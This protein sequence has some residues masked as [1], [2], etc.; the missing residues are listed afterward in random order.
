MSH[1]C[2]LCLKANWLTAGR[3][4]RS[5]KELTNTTEKQNPDKYLIRRFKESDVYWKM[6]SERTG[7]GVEGCDDFLAM[8]TG[9]RM[10]LMF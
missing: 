10:G 2:L 6:I 5:K 9:A 1:L 8:L 7:P 3:L 4:R